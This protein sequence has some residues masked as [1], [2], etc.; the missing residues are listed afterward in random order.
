VKSWWLVIALL[1]SVGINL[2]ILAAVGA[3]RWGKKPPPPREEQPLPPPIAGETPQRAIRL[4]DRLGLEG[5]QRRRFIARQGR[6]FV[7]AVQLRT[8]MAE[9]QRELRRELT[10]S[11]PD[12]ARIDVLLNDSARSFRAMEQAMAQNV[13]ESR[14]LLNAD[15]E[16][17]FLQFVAL[18]RPPGLGAGNEGGRRGGGDAQRQGPRPGQR[19]QR[20]PRG[21]PAW[22]E[23]PQDEGPEMRDG[24]PG[25]PPPRPPPPPQERWQGGQP[26]RQGQMGR[27]EGAGPPPLRPR[28]RRWPWWN[29]RFGG[30]QRDRPMPP[31]DGTPGTETPV[32]P[33]PR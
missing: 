14:R 12:Q 30:G 28:R 23:R 10:S 8:D 19:Q 15:Q 18:L 31:V 17:E 7:E 32:Q 4:A 5:E 24:E 20:P 33:P 25:E 22:E 1:L 26:G 2:G 27:G 21:G 29:R 11:Q 16:K 9:T 3:N 6:F 13:V